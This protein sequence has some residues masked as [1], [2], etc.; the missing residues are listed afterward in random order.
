MARRRGA[1]TLVCH[2]TYTTQTTTTTIANGVKRSADARKHFMLLV[3]LS[4]F[5]YVDCNG[6]HARIR[7]EPSR[8]SASEQAGERRAVDGDLGAHR[9][10]ARRGGG[11][12]QL[13]ALASR[14]QLSIAR[15]L[16]RK[17]QSTRKH[18]LCIEHKNYKKKEK[19]ERLMP[20]AY[21]RASR[22]LARRHAR[23][24]NDA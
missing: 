5:L 19:R 20:M 9:A 8:V 7:L 10:A 4:P 21:N 6:D 17:R 22:R 11:S 24:R 15:Q 16:A 1:L 18:I 23:A 12:R 14:L 3:L 2:H 13:R